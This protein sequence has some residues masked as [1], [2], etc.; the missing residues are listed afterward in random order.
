M[1]PAP[2]FLTL[3]TKTLRERVKIVDVGSV[4]NPHTATM[5]LEVKQHLLY[6]LHVAFILLVSQKCCAVQTN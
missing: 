1:E 3:M 4:F 5:L 2:V 6:G